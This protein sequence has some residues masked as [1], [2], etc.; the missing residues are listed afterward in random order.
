MRLRIAVL[1]GA[2]ALVACEEQLPP[3]QR[4][5]HTYEA[6]CFNA[7]VNVEATSYFYLKRG[8]GCV[9]FDGVSAVTTLCSCTAVIY[10]SSRVVEIRR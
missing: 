6:L 8:G 3:L 4:E 7:S 5:V 10:K 1:V 9:Q 2:V